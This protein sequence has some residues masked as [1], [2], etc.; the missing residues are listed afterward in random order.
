MGRVAA[1]ASVKDSPSGYRL[2]YDVNRIRRIFRMERPDVVEIGN[3][4]TAKYAD[5]GLLAEQDAA[6]L[7]VDGDPDAGNQT[8]PVLADKDG[9][10]RDELYVSIEAVSGGQ[11]PGRCER[12]RFI[13]RWSGWLCCWGLL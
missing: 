12:C 6:E 11:F 3:S 8:S 2:M 4:L 9:D 7:G 13:S 5:A 10:G 1:M